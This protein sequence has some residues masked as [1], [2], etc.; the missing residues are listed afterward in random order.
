MLDLIKRCFHIF[1]DEQTDIYVE[2]GRP[3][4]LITCSKCDYVNMIFNAHLKDSTL[5]DYINSL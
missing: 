3:I 2:T 4:I 5:V 1:H